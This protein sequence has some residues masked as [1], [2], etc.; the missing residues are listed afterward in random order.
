MSAVA[1][2]D[3]PALTAVV[4][5][6]RNDQPAVIAERSMPYGN[7]PIEGADGADPP[8]PPSPVPAPVPWPCPIADVAR[9]VADRAAA[10]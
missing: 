6:L 7:G 10:W 1:A 4:R 8:A 3:H 9:R 5:R 2:R